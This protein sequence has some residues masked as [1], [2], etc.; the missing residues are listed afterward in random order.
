MGWLVFTTLVIPP[1]VL[2][3]SLVQPRY[4]WSNAGFSGIGTGRDFWFVIIIFLFVG[5]MM[6]HK[7][8][9]LFIGAHTETLSVVAMRVGSPDRPSV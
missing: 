2:T 6:F 5:A 1:L 9:Q 4:R 8:G 7:R 3:R